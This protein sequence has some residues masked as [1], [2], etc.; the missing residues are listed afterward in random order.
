MGETTNAKRRS[1]PGRKNFNGID[2]L[3]RYVKR[4]SRMTAKRNTPMTYSFWAI[5]LC[6]SMRKIAE[7]R[8]R[9]TILAV[10]A[11][12]PLTTEITFYPSF[13]Y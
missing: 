10:S 7:I 6:A 12:L 8:A 3:V 1:I 13:Q 5:A 9:R 11:N 2:F 4:V